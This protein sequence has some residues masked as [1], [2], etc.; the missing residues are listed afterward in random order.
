MAEKQKP[1]ALQ[2]TQQQYNTTVALHRRDR[3]CWEQAGTEIK[4]SQYYVTA[5]CEPSLYGSTA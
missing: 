3:D 5:A 1:G 4:T 2:R